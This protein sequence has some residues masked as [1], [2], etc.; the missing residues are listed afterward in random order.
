MIFS[1]I[2]SSKHL[3]LSTIS[4]SSW[5]THLTMDPH[6]W[7]SCV[8]RQSTNYPIYSTA[9]ILSDKTTKYQK[10]ALRRDEMRYIREQGVAAFEQ[11]EKMARNYCPYFKVSLKTIYTIVTAFGSTID[12]CFLNI[13]SEINPTRPTRQ[14]LTRR[15]KERDPSSR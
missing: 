4:D 11:Q 9:K 15:D 2:I 5:T 6:I 10:K 8:R 1:V 12:C 7:G 14:A 3:M 13:S